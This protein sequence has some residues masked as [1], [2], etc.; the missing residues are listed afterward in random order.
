MVFLV[1]WVNSLHNLAL[2]GHRLGTFFASGGVRCFWW[3]F[4]LLVASVAS[5]G[6][7]CFW[8]RP[9]LLVASVAFGDGRCLWWRPLLLVASVAFGAHSGC[10]NACSG[11]CI[12]IL[13]A[14]RS[15]RASE[16][17]QAREAS[18]GHNVQLRAAT[19]ANSCSIMPQELTGSSK[20][21]SSDYGSSDMQ[22]LTATRANKQ[23]QD[24]ALPVH[25]SDRFARGSKRA[26]FFA[27]IFA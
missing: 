7:F 26:P 20:T 18:T 13:A 22:Q 11:C 23:P 15:A 4:L 6:V 2:F 27:S 8:W 9:L 5:G 3:R 19:A 21:T 17:S 10:Y 25:L 16:A 12:R 14:E 1:F 24:N